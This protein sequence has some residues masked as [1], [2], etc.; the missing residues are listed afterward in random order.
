MEL[1]EPKISPVQGADPATKKNALIMSHDQDEWIVDE[2]GDDE[3][4]SSCDGSGEIVTGWEFPNYE[5]CPACRG[6][7]KVRD[8]LDEADEQYERNR[9]DRT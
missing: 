9:D 3:S 5:T 1:R 8:I 4:C 7:G 6:S 2:Y